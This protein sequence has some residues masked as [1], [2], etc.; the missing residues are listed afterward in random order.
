M[1]REELYGLVGS[2]IDKCNRCGDCRAV[3]PVFA[4]EPMEPAVARGKLLLAG[5]LLR[6]EIQPSPAMLERLDKCLL[7]ESCTFECAFHLRV[8]RVV[9][10]TRAAIAESIGLPSAKRVVFDLLANHQSA[11][12]LICTAGNATSAIWGKRIPQESGLNLRFPL[13]GM[14]GDRVVPRP[15]ARPFRARVPEFRAA[16]RA[17]MTVDFF[18]GCFINHVGPTIGMDT[19]SV[20]GRAGVSVIIPRSQKCCGTPMAASGDLDT[21]LRLMRSNLEALSATNSDAVIV[22]CATCGTALRDLYP[23][24]LAKLDPSLEDAAKRLAAKTY[25]ITEFLIEHASIPDVAALTRKLRLTYHDSCH[26]AR[27][28]GVRVQPRKLLDSIANVELV[29]MDDADV[30]CGGAGA[31]SFTQQRLSR[32]ILARKT[33]SIV[34]TSADVVVSGCHG[35]NLQ[36]SEGLARVHAPIRTLHTVQVLEMAY[37]EARRK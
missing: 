33:E 14:A 18:T 19:L 36:I 20:L 17:K 1:R 24:M 15:A 9:M 27:G 28:L 3:C 12:G 37:R 16:N 22:A 5:R 35:C 2:Y 34:A 23:Q 29:E 26:L 32:A 25:D 10:A 7:C 13:A 4:Q 30:C 11:L 6:G 21:A 8:D 31:F